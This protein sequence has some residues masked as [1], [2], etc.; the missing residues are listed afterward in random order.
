MAISSELAQT[1]ADT[2]VSYRQLDHWMTRGYL[3]GRQAERCPGTGRPRHLTPDQIH[4]LR[5]MSALVKAG[6][7]PDAASRLTT[8]LRAGYA[9]RVGGY[10]LVPLRS[11]A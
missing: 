6:F 9:P 8:A 10:R 4:H 1:L 5:V 11:A 7:T 2:D 3:P